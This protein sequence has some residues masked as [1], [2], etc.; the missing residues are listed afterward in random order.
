[1]LGCL[2]RNVPSKVIICY[3]AILDF[4]YIAQ[5]PSHDDDTLQYLTNALALYHANKHI[6]TSPELAIREHLN[7]PKFHAMTHY[8]QAIRDFGTTD[9]YNIEMFEASS[10]FTLIVL[11][12][13][14][15][16]QTFETNSHRWS[17][18]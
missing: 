14:G 8:I 15:G 2:I 16:C 11:K 17:S 18:G 7:I 12:K 10:T 3:Q 9:N 4:V 1:M 5:Y 13:L 6:L